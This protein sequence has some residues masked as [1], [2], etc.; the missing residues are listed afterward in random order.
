MKPDPVAKM[1]LKMAEKDFT[2]IRKMASDKEYADEIFGFHAQ[3]AVEMAAKALLSIHLIAF[4]FTH[5]L[6]TL[7]DELVEHGCIAQEDFPD[8]IDLNDFAVQF[9]YQA[10]EELNI[11][12]DRKQIVHRVGMFL[13]FVAEEYRKAGKNE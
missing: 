3:Q 9:R 10:F 13:K 11:D 1:L 4:E 5:D 7:F 8:L 6:E 12:L 2:T